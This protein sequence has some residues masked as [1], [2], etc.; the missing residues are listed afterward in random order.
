MLRLQKLI[1]LLAAIGIGVGLGAC[2][3]Q[4][5]KYETDLPNVD[6]VEKTNTSDSFADTK[7]TTTPVNDNL[8][9]APDN[10]PFYDAVGGESLGR[11][12]YALYGVRDQSKIL[13]DNPNLKLAKK[14]DAG[15]KIFF[16][17]QT[18]RLQARYLTKGM[19]DRYT[20]DLAKVLREGAGELEK[21]EVAKGE[22]LQM[23]SKRL[24]G[25]TRYWTEIYLLN[26]EALPAYD[27]VTA[28]QTL[29]CI[30]RQQVAAVAKID[31]MPAGPERPEPAAKTQES[32][33]VP[34]PAK[35]EL[36]PAK[37][38]AAV[39]PPAITKVSIPVPVQ[40]I[41]PPPV[42]PIFKKEASSRNIGQS[43][44]ILNEASIRR[45]MYGL[46]LAFI[47][48]GTY[49]FAKPQRKNSSGMAPVIKSVSGGQA[50]RV[51]VPI[52]IASP[53]QKSSSKNQTG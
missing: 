14:I 46:L 28:G 43:N 9:D 11:V 22:T 13:A 20:S 16:Q 48:L 52:P 30:R 26:H 37:I 23:V 40:P 17:F 49:H 44:A 41:V 4:K 21:T 12:A 45:I 38:E 51:G 3:T 39:T 10:R 33:K 1:L 5:N 32:I 6:Q 34:E 18:L 19:L 42:A 36:V 53:T 8:S 50:P 31:T 25:T 27:K 2:A 47:L 15:Q 7:N 29:E 35:A 24:Y